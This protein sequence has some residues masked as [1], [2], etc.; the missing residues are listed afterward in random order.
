VSEEKL[1]IRADMRETRSGVTQLL[2]K[3]ALVRVTFE[4]LPI[5]DFVL[6]DEVCVE[7]KEAT[8]FVNSIMD[9]RIFGQVASMKASFLRPVVIIEGDVF[10]TRSAISKEALLGALS[11][12]SVIEGVGTIYTRSVAETAAF[13]E[14]MCRHA[15]NGLGYEIP[16]RGAKAKN[17]D[18]LAQ[19]SVEGLPSVGPTTAKKLLQHFGS[20][21]GVYG[22]PEAQLQGVKGVDKKMAEQIVQL[23]D[24]AYMP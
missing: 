20:V 24:H 3:S 2:Q 19:Y 21:R 8:D 12:L 9:R 6:S 4:E 7:R 22:A 5:G 1:L 18:V 13:L 14:V 11:W 15:Q 23:V 16:L 10:N 17:L